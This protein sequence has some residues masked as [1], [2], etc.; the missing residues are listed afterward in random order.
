MN[1]P[2]LKRSDSGRYSCGKGMDTKHEVPEHCL[3]CADN[4]EGIGDVD[5]RY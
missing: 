3:Y 2:Y 4:P 1:C 5:P